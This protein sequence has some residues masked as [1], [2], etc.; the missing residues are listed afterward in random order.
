[1]VRAE[2]FTDS[3]Q[4]LIRTICGSVGSGDDTTITRS[5]WRRAR[6]P[7]GLSSPSSTT[8]SWSISASC[9]YSARRYDPAAPWATPLIPSDPRCRSMSDAHRWAV[10]P[11]RATS[12][13]KSIVQPWTSASA[14]TA[15]AMT[16]PPL[17]AARPPARPR[18]V[19][20]MWS[21][22]AGWV[23]RSA[24]KA[25]RSIRAMV[26]SRMAMTVA[27]RGA[28]STSPSS[29][30]IS[31]RPSSAIRSPPSPNTARRP[32]MTK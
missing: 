30:T 27:L 8:Y 20:A 18:I 12:R 24:S 28:D 11:C 6:S 21:M 17:V 14:A 10:A 15:T 4:R 16:M 22:I 13:A 2:G 3:S 32:L 5:A 25:A 23:A 1:M 26:V 31:P 19:R 29:P 9:R 7:H